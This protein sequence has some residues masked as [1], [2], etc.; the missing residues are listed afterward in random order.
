MTP[1]GQILVRQ[2]P[3][4]H[5]VTGA[6][7]EKFSAFEDLQKILTQGFWGRMAPNVSF[8]NRSKRRIM[9]IAILN[10]KPGLI[11]DDKYAIEIMAPLETNEPE[12]VRRAEPN[13]ILRINIELDWKHP[14]RIEEKKRFYKE[15]LKGWPIHFIF[16]KQLTH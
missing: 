4:T 3:V 12:F 13:Q 15:Q 14:E 11:Y 7:V 5:G 16:H 9:A 6:F 1:S 2:H 10:Q 8:V